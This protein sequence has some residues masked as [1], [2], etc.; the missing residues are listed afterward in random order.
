MKTRWVN[1]VNTKR[2]MLRTRN[3]GAI[4]E[5]SIVCVLLIVMTL[6]CLNMLVLAIGSSLTERATRDAAR[7]AAQANNYQDA[8]IL[9]KTAVNCYKGDGYFVDTPTINVSSFVYNDF[10]GAPPANTS[11]YVQVTATSQI[12]F[13]API[14]VYGMNLGKNTQLKFSK[15]YTFPIIVTAQ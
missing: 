5:F 9:A 6:F 8:L 11:P 14:F 1:I 2:A 13:P 15:T 3:G 4:L 12:R 10:G 7:M